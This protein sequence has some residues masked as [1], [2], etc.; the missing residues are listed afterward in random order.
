MTDATLTPIV[1]VHCHV[2][3]ADFDADR[4]AVLAEAQR[5]GI[6]TLLIMGEGEADNARVIELAARHPQLRPC[7]GLHP[8]FV[9]REDVARVVAQVR[10]AHAEHPLTAVGEIGLDYFVAKTEE[11]RQQQRAA[12]RAMVELSL[13][14]DLPLSLHSRSAGHY[15]IDLLE[16]LGA[17]RVCLHAFDGRASHAERG[18]ALGYYYSVPPSVVRSRQKQNLVSR[19]PLDSLLL[20]SDAPALGPER[21]ERNVPGNIALVVETI[22]ELKGVSAEQVR[23]AALANARALFRLPAAT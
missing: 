18:A 9:D 20:E 7:L 19:L 4:E 1:D 16:A 13:E 3:H 2:H 12:M 5:A 17:R 8:W 14:L 21:G 10:A 23:Q 6:E 15:T 11:Q 22:A